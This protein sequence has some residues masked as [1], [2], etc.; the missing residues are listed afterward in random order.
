M[1]G[2]PKRKLSL[3]TNLL[4]DLAKPQ[5]FAHE[6]REEFQR[7]GYALMLP[8]TVLAELE[9]LI[10]FGNGTTRRLAEMASRKIQEWHLTPF[11][12]PEVH[13]TIAEEFARRLEYQQLI[14][15]D[16]LNDGKIL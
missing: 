3:D 9:F 6:F 13:D 4:L 1:V 14:P 5:D 12:L 15:A 16:E 10:L 2:S 7:R 11:D 8:P